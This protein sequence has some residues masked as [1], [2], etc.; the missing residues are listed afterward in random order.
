MSKL[1][2]LLVDGNDVDREL[3]RIKLRRVSSEFELIESESAKEAV[4]MYPAASS[5]AMEKIARI[6]ELY[7]SRISANGEPPFA[8][9]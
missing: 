9:F 6:A 5:K 1:K 7:R 8:G 2:V 3:I 4:E